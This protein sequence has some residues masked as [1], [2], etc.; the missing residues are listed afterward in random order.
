MTELDFRNKPR[1]IVGSLITSEKKNS[2]NITFFTNHL[3]SR[4][5]L[6][7]CLDQK[8]NYRS[9]IR[10]SLYTHNTK[11][12]TFYWV[13]GYTTFPVAF[14][15]NVNDNNNNNRISNYLRWCVWILTCST[16]TNRATT[17]CMKQLRHGPE[18]C[19]WLVQVTSHMFLTHHKLWSRFLHS[20]NA[21]FPVLTFVVQTMEGGVRDFHKWRITTTLIINI[22]YVW[23]WRFVLKS[24]NTRMCY[25]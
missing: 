9:F 6:L 22:H 11:S 21:A 13:E 19:V 2:T 4:K 1:L 20:K 7:D 18:I 3:L 16:N 10:T 25:I 23:K 24:T 8:C 15:N 12:T 5:E 14:N 17:S